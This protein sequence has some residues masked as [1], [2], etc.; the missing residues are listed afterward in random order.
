[1]TY[2]VTER[3]GV[4]K[5]VVAWAKAHGCPLVPKMG[6]AYER[7]WPDRMFLVPG[8]RP[9]FI[10]FKRPG[11][12]PTAKQ[13]HRIQELRELG[14]DVQVCDNKE[15]GIEIVRSRL[16][17]A[18]IHAPKRQVAAGARRRGAVP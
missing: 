14:Y 10:E 15:E 1:M 2:R 9:L 18:R 5:P 3:T 13:A 8:G 11:K 17:A 6:T 7:S 4:E 12:E 16:E